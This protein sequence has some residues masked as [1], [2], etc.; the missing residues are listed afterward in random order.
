M[1]EPE[2]RELPE[3]TALCV[4]RTGMIDNNFTKAAAEAFGVLDTFVAKNSLASE[5]HTCIGI[6]PDDPRNIEPTTARYQGGFIFK[7]EVEP[8]GEIEKVT[9]PAG[10]WAVITH[11]GSYETLGETWD[12]A[13]RDWLPASGHRLR[14]IPPYEIYLGEGH[15]DTPGEMVTEIH[16]PVE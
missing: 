14:N 2:I 9:I 4:T 3:R 5:I 16:I 13:F 15:D 10:R 8:E 1:M 11:R 12:S 6:C 7:R